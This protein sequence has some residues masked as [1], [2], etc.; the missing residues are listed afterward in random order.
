MAIKT[1]QIELDDEVVYRTV[2]P[3]VYRRTAWRTAFVYNRYVFIR[4]VG[5]HPV[6]LRKRY[7]LDGI[8]WYLY[9]TR[10]WVINPGSGFWFRLPPYP[11]GGFRFYSALGTTVRLFW[12]EIEYEDED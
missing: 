4:N 9:G 10:L 8:H 12:W 11:W 5:L 6:Y 2:Y 3:G 7:S 1:K